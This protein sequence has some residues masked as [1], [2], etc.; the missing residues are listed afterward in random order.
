MH[1]AANPRRLPPG[2][3]VGH[4]SYEGA[5]RLAGRAQSLEDVAPHEASTA[6]DEDRHAGP[7][8]GM[9]NGRVTTRASRP[10]ARTTAPTGTSRRMTASPIQRSAPATHAMLV[11]RPT[12]RSSSVTELQPSAGGA[13][14]SVSNSRPRRLRLAWPRKCSRLTVSCPVKQPFV[15]DTPPIS[16]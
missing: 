4:V 7:T 9:S 5:D 6:G 11:T 14:E 1:D 12:S 8:A 13:G 10:A 15:Y 16:S 3:R 2:R